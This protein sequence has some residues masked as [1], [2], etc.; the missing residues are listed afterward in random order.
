VFA[1][2]LH[3]VGAPADIEAGVGVYREQILPWARDVTGFRG[4]VVLLDR[5]GGRA[6]AMSLWESEEAMLA[7]EESGQRFRG[8]VAETSGMELGAIESYEVAMLELSP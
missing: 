4:Y 3:V 8:M 2:V 7:F 1:R 6:M 5:E